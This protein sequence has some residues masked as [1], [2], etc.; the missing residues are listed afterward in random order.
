MPDTRRS[1]LGKLLRSPAFCV[2]IMRSSGRPGS[3][4]SYNRQPESGQTCVVIRLPSSVA[5]HLGDD[6][7]EAVVVATGM[8]S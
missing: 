6:I 5:D 2:P 3:M 1:A 4:V 8:I 7:T